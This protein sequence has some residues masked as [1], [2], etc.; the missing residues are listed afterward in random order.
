MSFILKALKKLENEKSARKTAP[1][2]IDSAIL[3]PD[4]RS[5]SPPHSGGKWMIITLVL[6][7]GAGAI[8]F[9]LHKTSS[10]VTEARKVAPQ[11]AAAPTA[12]LAQTIQQ[13][14]ERPAQEGARIDTPVPQPAPARAKEPEKRPERAHVHNE[15]T[16]RP[17]PE[18]QESF[19]A[20][21]PG[22]TVNGIALQDDPSESMAVEWSA[23]E[24]RSD[25]RRGAG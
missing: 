23:G 9:F 8:Y 12:P 16:P 10:S 13:P 3:A 2:E 24:D 1:V 15:F 5:F 22:L 21:S 6:L 14:V 4:S 19:V 20:A 25:C 11:P 17:E 18:H 7:A